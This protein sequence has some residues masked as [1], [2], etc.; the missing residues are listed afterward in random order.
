MPRFLTEFTAEMALETPQILLRWAF[1]PA[2]EAD[3]Q[4]FRIV[5]RS[6]RWAVNAADGE[7]LTTWKASQDIPKPTNF[8][9]RTVDGVSLYHY[10]MEVS[11]Q[12]DPM[13]LVQSEVTPRL[14]NG[15]YSGR[16]E[17]MAFDQGATEDRYSVA[18][19]DDKGSNVLQFFNVGKDLIEQEFSL[20]ALL[21]AGEDIVSLGFT[22]PLDGSLTGIAGT[23]FGRIL[24]FSYAVGN[25]IAP[26]FLG[27]WPIR[28]TEIVGVDT[29][30]VLAGMC[31][32][33]PGG[34]GIS[35]GAFIVV[36]DG[37]LYE[38]PPFRRAYKLAIADGVLQDV[39]DYGLMTDFVSISDIAYDHTDNRIALAL[40]RK[41]VAYPASDLIPANVPVFSAAMAGAGDGPYTLTLGYPVGDTPSLALGSISIRD[42][43]GV[44]GRDLP[45]SAIVGE[46]VTE[47]GAAV[48]VLSSAVDYDQGSI[49]V[50]FD[51]TPTGSVLV[52]Y[53][54]S[55][56]R[57][58]GAYEAMDGITFRTGLY[59]TLQNDGR[60]S[61][62]EASGA[63]EP[64]FLISEWQT[65]RVSAHS[66]RVYPD[67]VFSFRDEHYQLLSRRMRGVDHSPIFLDTTPFSKVIGANP[68][69]TF[70]G[71]LEGVPIVP[72]SVIVQDD[73]SSVGDITDDG[74]GNFGG[75]GFGSINYENGEYTVTFSDPDPSIPIGNVTILWSQVPVSLRGDHIGR[76]VTLPQKHL[77]RFVRFIG[78]LLDRT[79]DYRD[80][81]HEQLDIEKAMPEY[82]PHLAFKSGVPD[83]NPD[84]NL[85][86]QRLYLSLYPEVLRQRGTLGGFKLLLKYYG[87]LLDFTPSQIVPSRQF[88][89][90]TTV[91]PPGFEFD[92]PTVFDTSGGAF[93]VNFKLKFRRISDLEVM[94]AADPTTKFLLGRL[95]KI[96]PFNTIL[97]YTEE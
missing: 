78:L 80:L 68:D 44:L 66:G 5:R 12:A 64:V 63:S 26:A 13:S 65:H 67:P 91:S 56:F 30:A 75:A 39:V 94:P 23:S 6:D 17:A 49:T 79:V 38:T 89:D 7:V 35:V 81:L 45:I 47:P 97:E 27:G 46:I 83:L 32:E 9:D 95:E 19:L 16:A 36:L 37:T 87:Y 70:T 2:F 61:E 92:F 73:S 88:F 57:T 3:I 10:V 85:D 60:F 82:L 25:D 18:G 22:G 77:E 54:D 84:F 55:D 4:E 51:G 28:I 96:K 41:I 69:K 42:D 24:K 50:T 86:R 21:Q 40:G 1:D 93:V 43:N 90:S 31:V 76:E 52:D 33:F 48:N 15:R 29:R 58:V 53:S 34:Y 20:E 74:A 8:A 71:K 62:W 11:Y 14:I 59:I 72:G